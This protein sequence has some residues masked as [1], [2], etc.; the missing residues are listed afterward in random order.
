MLFFPLSQIQNKLTF[1]VVQK[2]AGKQTPGLFFLFYRKDERIKWQKYG[3]ERRSIIVQ[4][5]FG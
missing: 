4:A 2:V 1:N 5:K 3:D